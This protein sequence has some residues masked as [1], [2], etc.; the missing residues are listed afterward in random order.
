MAFEYIVKTLPPV[1]PGKRHDTFKK[2]PFKTQWTAT[3]QLLARE[4][5]L[6][7]GTHVEV[8]VDLPRGEYDLRADGQLR[9]DARPRRA[10]IVSFRMPDGTRMSFPCDTYGWWQDNVYAIAKTLE[11]LRAVDRW[12]A[13]QSR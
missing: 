1:W 11:N 12:G 9:A 13:T 3:L 8:A 6:L 2:S 5:K 7:G 10:V 4:I